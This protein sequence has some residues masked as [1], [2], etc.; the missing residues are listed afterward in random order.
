MLKKLFDDL[1]PTVKPIWFASGSIALASVAKTV[2]TELGG[3][4]G[5]GELSSLID[6]LRTVLLRNLKAGFTCCVICED[7]QDLDAKQL[8]E[9]RQLDNLTADGRNL[10]PTILVGEPALIKKLSE[11]ESLPFKQ[12]VALSSRLFILPRSEVDRYVKYQLQAVGHRGEDLFDAGAMDRL[13]HYSGGIPRLVNNLCDNALLA[14]YRSSTPQISPALIDAVAAQ[15]GLVSGAADF[16]KWHSLGSLSPVSLPREALVRDGGAEWRAPQDSVP[17]K[18][19]HRWTKAASVACLLLLGAGSASWAVYSGAAAFGVN[20]GVIDTA[21]LG[22]RSPQASSP[23]Q[24]HPHH[25]SMVDAPLPSVGAS[26]PE[27][28]DQDK[29][30]KKTPVD[31]ST[32]PGLADD[33]ASAQTAKTAR[34]KAPLDQQVKKAI[35]A[36]AIEGVSVRV[37]GGNVYLGGVVASER[38]KAMAE[39]AALAVQQITSMTNQIKIRPVY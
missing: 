1:A 10:L 5:A 18:P 15:M 30:S 14:A 25:G 24:N 3:A 7:A 31:P 16:P 9:L 2:L 12:R 32:A 28:P 6:A 17:A 22:R 20:R 4:A 35:E 37:V 36:R 34:T 39:K 21:V 38:Q 33:L 23:I 27:I 13:A 19:K 11:P 26:A 29:A 8:D